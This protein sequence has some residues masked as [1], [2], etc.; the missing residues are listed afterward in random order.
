M[1]LRSAGN[2][3]DGEVKPQATGAKPGRSL[4]AWA[5]RARAGA[6][7]ERAGAPR[8]RTK[9]VLSASRL[10]VVLAVLAMG[11]TA[12]VGVIGY[13]LARR[14]DERVWS[15]QR[16]S[17]NNAISEFRNLFGKSDAVDPRFVRIVEQSVGLKG[18]AFEADPGASDREVLPVMDAQGRI[19]GFLTWEKIHLMMDAMQ[20]LMPF[21]FAIAIVIVAFVGSSHAELRPARS[22]LP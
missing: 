18:L 1:P 2:P 15:E 16:V 9:R 6:T 4:L 22:Q 3:V 20:R 21:I 7:R 13:D 14:S 8:A 10:I 19:A 12:L 11:A 17:L 5:R